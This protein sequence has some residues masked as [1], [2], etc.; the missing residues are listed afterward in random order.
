MA[1]KK[2]IEITA[3]GVAAY[4]HVVAGYAVEMQAGRCMVNVDCYASAE[5]CA[6]RKNPL[7][8]ESITIGEIPPLDVPSLAWIEGKLAEQESSAPAIA[9]EI[10]PGMPM[11]QMYVTPN[12]WMFSGAEIV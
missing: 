5:A 4:H 1:L 3:Y 8:R 9:G 11:P 10:Q 2:E 7:A 12:R 6:A